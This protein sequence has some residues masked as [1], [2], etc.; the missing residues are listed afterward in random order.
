MRGFGEI[1]EQLRRSTVQVFS[2]RRRGGGS[3][4][5][6]KPDGLIVTNAHVAREAQT[7]VEFW[8]GR[9]FEARVVA[10]DPRRDLAAL[11]IAARS[12]GDLSAGDFA[13]NPGDSGALRPG[14]LVIAVGSPL[15]F[16][17]ALSTGVVHSIGALPGMGRQ[18]WVR[19][20]VRLAPGNSGGPLAN[21]RGDVIGINTAIVN[22]LGVA[23]PS[24]AVAGFLERGAS[25]SL[26]VTLRPVS[27]GLQILD[28]DPNGAAA[29]ASLRAG[30]ILVGSFDS[31]S[32]ALDSGRDVVRLQFF[33]GDR[34]K[35]REAF[36]RLASR[37]VAA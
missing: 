15:G 9:R 20:D 17:G 22:G 34:T 12:A 11:R 31:L 3:G 36:V 1:A 30:D 16:S 19:A 18:D 21:A 35:V 6:W 13:A 24:N 4:V 26:G 7:Q 5:V 10:H 2:D 37:A 33:R 23:V 14:E 25:P 8:D 28:L 32:E 27:F 29:T